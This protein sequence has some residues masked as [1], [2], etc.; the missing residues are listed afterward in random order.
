MTIEYSIALLISYQLS[1]TGRKRLKDQLGIYTKGL[2]FNLVLS[3]SSNLYNNESVYVAQK[4]H[5]YKNIN[6]NQTN[7]I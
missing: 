3:V 4:K 5:R 7:G 2:I 1:S 6:P